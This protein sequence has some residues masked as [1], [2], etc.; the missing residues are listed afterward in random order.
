LGI[1][2]PETCR[3]I[4]AVPED[5]YTGHE[6]AVSPDGKRA[7]VPIYGNAGVGREG[8]DGQLIRVID[9]E[10][11][12]VVGTIDL[13]QGARPHGAVFGPKDRLLYVTAELLNSVVVIDP[14]TLN[15][16]GK[17][18]TGKPESHMLAIT[19]DGKR[20]YT[21]N[22]GSGTVSVLDLEN[23][24][25]LSV[26]QVASVAQRIALSV[27]DAWAFTADQTKPQL[28]VIDTKTEKVSHR[29]ELPGIA[30]G[31]APTPD[32]KSLLVVLIKNNQLGLVDLG[33]MQFVKGLELPKTPQEVLVRPDGAKAFVSC[34]AS[35]KVAVIDLREW[36]VETL[37]AAGPGADG[38]AW[39]PR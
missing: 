9:L 37:I 39:A 13:G 6:V 17:V 29:V 33:R 21:S 26:I 3:Q 5:G 19:S 4:A 14:A 34:D 38:L 30:Y 2:D 12:S 1:I 8:T 27:D 24:K 31:T 36:K 7:F 32:G 28:A 35:Q 25:L 18:P 11:R 23:R 15:I 22:V 10:Q 20:G 16:I